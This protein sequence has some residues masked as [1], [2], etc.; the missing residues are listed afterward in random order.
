MGQPQSSVLRT[1]AEAFR[2]VMSRTFLIDSIE[3]IRGGLVLMEVL[4]LDS[5]SASGSCARMGVRSTYRAS[6]VRA[7]RLR[8]ACRCIRRWIRKP[9]DEN[10]LIVYSSGFHLRAAHFEQERC[11]GAFPCNKV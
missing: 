7:L 6:K 10:S 4:G 3:S 1:P 9:Q 2:R 11:G 5:Q 8:Y